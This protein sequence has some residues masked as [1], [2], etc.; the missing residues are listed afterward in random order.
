MTPAEAVAHLEPFWNEV[1]AIAAARGAAQGRDEARGLLLVAAFI[2]SSIERH[3][4]VAGF[5]PGSGVLQLPHAPA[6]MKKLGLLAC[7]APRDTVYT[8]A[9]WNTW[10]LSFTGEREERLLGD[11]IETTSRSMAAAAEKL[12]P[13]CARTIRLGSEV[14]LAHLGAAADEV[15]WSRDAW[16]KLRAYLGGDAARRA[17]MRRLASYFRPYPVASAVHPGIVVADLPPYWEARRM[18]GA[19]DSESRAYVTKRLA[20]IPNEERRPVRETMSASTVEQCV[21]LRLGVDLPSVRALTTR[22]FEARGRLLGR[23]FFPAIK[24]CG[25]LIQIHDELRADYL[26]LI[27]DHLMPPDE[28]VANAGWLS[29][30][31]RELDLMTFRRENPVALKFKAAARS[32]PG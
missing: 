26:G 2:V 16:R 9:M 3:Y 13:I 21:L 25:D 24:A 23:G 29:Q 22:E 32:A 7:H 31:V 19:W 15:A 20:H 1:A 14:S 30:A 12:R 27:V 28:V 5:D 17:T 4:Q 8:W 11:V 18:L 10:K 6:V